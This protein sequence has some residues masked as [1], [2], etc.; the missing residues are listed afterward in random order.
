M[1]TKRVWTGTAWAVV[2]YDKYAVFTVTE[3]EGAWWIARSGVP[4]IRCTSRPIAFI[5]EL[6][7]H[8]AIKAIGGV[9]NTR[10][11]V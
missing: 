5:A 9:G 10:F 3:H 1:P 6:K 7:L 2:T 11:F 8:T 4:E